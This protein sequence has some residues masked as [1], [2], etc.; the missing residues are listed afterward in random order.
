MLA[1]EF[2]KN[3]RKALFRADGRAW[4]FV[5]K[6]CMRCICGDCNQSSSL[7][8]RVYPVC[9]SGQ[10]INFGLNGVDIFCGQVPSLFHMLSAWFSLVFPCFSWSL[11]LARVC[12]RVPLVCGMPFIP[13]LAELV[14]HRWRCVSWSAFITT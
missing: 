9:N 10:L 13:I 11:R 5:P 6:N 1:N 3:C 8:W 12:A 14:L 2:L 7:F 4:D